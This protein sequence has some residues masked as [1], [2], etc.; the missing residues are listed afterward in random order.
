VKTESQADRTPPKKAAVLLAKSILKGS[1]IRRTM[2]N[3]AHKN[4]GQPLHGARV[5]LHGWW[6]TFH[7]KIVL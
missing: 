1:G 5:L 6:A 3:G 4:N 2:L 7:M